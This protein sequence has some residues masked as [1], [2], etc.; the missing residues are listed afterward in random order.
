MNIARF[1]AVL[2]LALSLSSIAVAQE[3]VV[4]NEEF[5]V[6]IT[7]P[8]AWEVNASDDKAVANFKHPD[9]NSQIQV[10]GTKLMS[11]D[12]ADVFFSTFHKTLT[13]S[14]FEEVSAADS[15]IGE[16]QGRLS[17]YSYTHSG[18]TVNVVVFD[19]IREGTA[20]LVIGY[21]PES[22]SEKLR[23]DFDAT[24]TSMSFEAAE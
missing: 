4:E 13:E 16:Q 2:L 11:K 23:A 24:V 14:N 12:V 6:T 10:I 20:W 15:S 17:T 22:E 9:S 3:T 21:M 5:G 19:F 18:Q 1:F 8:S 7:P